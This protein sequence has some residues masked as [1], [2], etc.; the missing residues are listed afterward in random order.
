[1]EGTQRDFRL[2]LTLSFLH[3]LSFF[4]YYSA[5]AMSPSGNSLAHNFR[6]CQGICPRNAL[7]VGRC[8]GICQ[9]IILA[10]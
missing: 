8:L 9:T 5:H 1:M 6:C 7:Q 3:R 4:Y 2:S 10:T